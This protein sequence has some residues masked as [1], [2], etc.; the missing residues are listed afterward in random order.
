MRGGATEK[1]LDTNPQWGKGAKVQVRLN[2]HNTRKIRL[3]A[4]RLGVS[5]PVI[6]NRVIGR[7]SSQKIT[8]QRKK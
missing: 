2:A 1:R 6:V 3:V 5:V 8:T 7:I 4:A